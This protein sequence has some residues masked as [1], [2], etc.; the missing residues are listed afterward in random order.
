[1]I[2]RHKL[3]PRK[4][5]AD[6]MALPE[7]TRAELIDGEILMSPS[8][9]SLHQRVVFQLAKLL[10]GVVRAH[11]LGEVLISPLDV[12]LPSGDIVE[13]DIVFIS[14]RNPGIVQ[15]WIRGVP[16]L[17]VEVLSPEGIPRDRF[18]K[19]DLYARNGVAEYWIVD[20]DTRSVEVFSLAGHRYEPTGFFES[21]DRIESS[22]LP[23]FQ[24]PAAE[25]FH[26]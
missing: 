17:V 14:N 11:R 22:L 18:V 24:I 10:D 23:D 19:R 8:P 26:W 5:I 7:G 13:P 16:D 9:R 20:P 25:L 3:R 2:V 21:Q 12:H 1:M 4:T 15:D 6:F